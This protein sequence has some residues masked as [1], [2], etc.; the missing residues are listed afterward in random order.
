[1][2]E[3]DPFDDDLNDYDGTWGGYSGFCLA[4]DMYGVVNETSLCPDCSPLLERDLIRQRDWDYSVSAY[5]LPPEAREKLREEVIKKYGPGLE[6]I[7][8]NSAPAP[9]RKKR[10]RR[11]RKKG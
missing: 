1:M 6:L 3:I 5:A 9:K 11:R 8:D 2:N 7:S 4:C 10:P